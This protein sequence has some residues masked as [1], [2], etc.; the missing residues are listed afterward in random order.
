MVEFD[1]ERPSPEEYNHLRDIVGW[2]RYDPQSAVDGLDN[3]LYTAAL[4]EDGQL[5]AFGRVIGD[6]RITFY[7]QDVIV[8]PEKRGR[9]YARMIMDRLMAYIAEAA[10]PNAVVG[11]MSAGGV[12]ELYEKYGFIR[13]PVGRFGAGM[14]LPTDWK[15]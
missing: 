10:A 14:T 5:V 11:L 6:G 15:D 13:R 3:S 4:R 8:I 9:G 1:E 7:I 2:G 12:E